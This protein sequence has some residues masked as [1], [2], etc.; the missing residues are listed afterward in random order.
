[1]GSTYR[2]KKRMFD[3]LGYDEQLEMVRAALIKAEESGFSD[4]TTEQIMETVKKR[5]RE[6]GQL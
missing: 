2:R 6:D 3:S 5:L 4:R 1:M